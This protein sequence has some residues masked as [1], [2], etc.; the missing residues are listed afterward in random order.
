M[1]QNSIFV[2]RIVSRERNRRGCTQVEL[3]VE[4]QPLEVLR[5]TRFLVSPHHV[6]GLVE[7]YGLEVCRGQL[8]GELASGS[9][10]TQCRQTVPGRNSPWCNSSTAADSTM[11]SVVCRDGIVC[12]RVVGGGK[13]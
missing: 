1:S 6:D 9:S 2:G 8:G 3:A 10:T 7:P 4:K 5:D 12:A 13:S 11:K